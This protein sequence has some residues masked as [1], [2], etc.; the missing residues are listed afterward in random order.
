[1]VET[2][3]DAVGLEVGLEFVDRSRRRALREP[4]TVVSTDLGSRTV[5]LASHWRI[6]EQKWPFEIYGRFGADML[7]ATSAFCAEMVEAQ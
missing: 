7:D 6:S 4:A 3:C 2:D 1:M 5:S